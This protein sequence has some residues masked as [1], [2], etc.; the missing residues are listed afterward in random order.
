MNNSSNHRHFSPSGCLTSEAINLYIQKKLT[1]KEVRKIELHLTD[2]QFCSDAI[3]GLII[4]DN[5]DFET[6]LSE[7]RDKL[8]PTDQ[9]KFNGKTI[10]INKKSNRIRNIIYLS[11]AASI[12]VII[13][14]YLSIISI[15]N[16]SKNN[17]LLGIE[18]FE[19]KKSESPLTESTF[20]D[21]SNN[22]KEAQKTDTKNSQGSAN[23]QNNIDRI[24][25]I[26]KLLKTDSEDEIILSD[27][28]SELS[29]NFY[30]PEIIN[31]Q[32]SDDNNIVDGNSVEDY[33]KME[34][35]PASSNGIIAGYSVTKEKESNDKNTQRSNKSSGQN[36]NSAGSTKTVPS[37]SL[38]YDADENEVSPAGLDKYN[39]GDYSGA[40]TYYEEYLHV[41]PDDAQAQYYCG[42][43]HY[44]LK[45]YNKALE[46]LNKVVSN[47]Q[48]HFYQQ[49]QWQ[50]AQIYIETNNT[51]QARK[52]LNEIIDEKGTYLNNAIEAVNNLENQ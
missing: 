5:K 37:F 25:I 49:A 7:V 13:I 50:I 27:Y 36:P 18:E 24:E 40:I 23:N 39:A 17:S 22:K 51:Q 19:N 4:S 34:E 20:K 45:Q 6:T 38:S 46:L 41:Y 32:P 8:F 30:T 44:K 52:V 42:M 43:S 26:N 1:D 11:I 33:K 35:L 28:S 16:S 14:S 3:D 21:S 12:S 31:T 48:N 9:K 29:D 15:N 2:C 10:N 47:K